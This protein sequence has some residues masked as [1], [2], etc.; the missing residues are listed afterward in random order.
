MKTNL[1]YRTLFAFFGLLIIFS[2]ASIRADENSFFIEG[3]P[4]E[5]SVVQGGEIGFHISSTAPKFSVEITRLGSKNEVVWNKKNLPG[6]LH[7]VP[8][9][10]SANGCGWP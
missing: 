8:E 9:D 2:S 3:Y 1:T 4:G 7:P 10:A 6:Q 5:I